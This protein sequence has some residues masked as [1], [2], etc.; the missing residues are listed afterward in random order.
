MSTIFHQV[1]VSQKDNYVFFE[2]SNDCTNR[3]LFKKCIQIQKENF[4]DQL[5]LEINDSIE[6]NKKV[7]QNKKIIKNQVDTS[8][9]ESTGRNPIVIKIET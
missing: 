5:S 2:I 7:I 1:P 4:S 3:E 9:Y 8:G 6:L